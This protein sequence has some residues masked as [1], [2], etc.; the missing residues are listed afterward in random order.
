LDKSSLTPHPTGDDGA[1]LAALGI[2]AYLIADVLHEVVGH[3]TACLMSGARITL[4]TSVYFRCSIRTPVIAAAGPTANLVASG[5]VWLVQRHHGIADARVRL[6]ILLMFAFNF[7]WGAGS[8]VYHSITNQDDWAIAVA[9]LQPLWLWRVG[10]VVL[11]SALYVI[12]VRRVLRSV[13]GFVAA[14]DT[15]SATHRARRLVLVPYAAAGVAAC[16]A[17][18][19]YTFDPVRAVR[20]G[21]LEV[22]ASVGGLLPALPNVKLRDVLPP[23][24]HIER[25]GKWIGSVAVALVVFTALLGAGVR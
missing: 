6:L 7:F 20:E 1:T 24:S 11:G 15:A 12:G 3:G 25:S 2:A 10:L 18:A 4:L 5:L 17:A 16:F 8:M 14:V 21:A 13:S 23:L 22:V 19:F 9:E